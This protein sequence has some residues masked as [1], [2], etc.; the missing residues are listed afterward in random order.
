MLWV[1]AIGGIPVHTIS[2]DIMFWYAEL[3]TVLK[4]WI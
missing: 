3:P 4:G 2:L 1:L